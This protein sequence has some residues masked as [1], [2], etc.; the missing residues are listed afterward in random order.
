MDWE[1]IKEKIYY[2]DGSWRDIYI[3][4]TTQGDWK[5]W[6]DFVNNNYEVE[7][8]SGQ[9]QRQETFIDGFTIIKYWESKESLINSATIKLN[10]III[11]CYFFSVEEIEN[12]ID[13][14][15]ITTIDDHNKLLSYMINISKLLDKTVIM[16][17]ENMREG[18]YIAV[19]HDDIKLTLT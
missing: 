16:T 14:R 10:T 9:T 13:P 1:E 18:V 17:A 4:N 15:E 2:W 6:I 11:K 3:Q 5:K 8:Y 7:F 12:D 19:Y